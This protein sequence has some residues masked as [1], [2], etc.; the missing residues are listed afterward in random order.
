MCLSNG[1]WITLMDFKRELGREGGSERKR[2]RT[3]SEN[4]KWIINSIDEISCQ[5]KIQYWQKKFPPPPRL[6]LSLRFFNFPSLIEIEEKEH[7]NANKFI[8]NYHIY[9]LHNYYSISCFF[10]GCSASEQERITFHL[11]LDEKINFNG[12]ITH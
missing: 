10:Y 1:Y 6:S 11:Y 3:S 8:K 12:S 7:N 2:E 5:I 9:N 4:L